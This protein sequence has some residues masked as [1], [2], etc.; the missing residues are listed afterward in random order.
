MEN[1]RT[2]N[3]EHLKIFDLETVRGW[4]QLIGIVGFSSIFVVSFLGF[5]SM[6]MKIYSG[7]ESDWFAFSL[8]F[9]CFLGLFP[10]WWMARSIKGNHLSPLS[11]LVLSCILPPVGFYFAYLRAYDK[12][13]FAKNLKTKTENEFII[14]K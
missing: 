7:N 4:L 3:V 12:K 5:L 8:L 6:G 2:T 9:I 14:Y 10:A 1:L 13:L 11:L